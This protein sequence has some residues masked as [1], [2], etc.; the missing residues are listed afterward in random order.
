M[1]SQFA[2]LIFVLGIVL[3]GAALADGPLP[4]EQNIPEWKSL[5]PDLEVTEF[6]S[7]SP[8]LFS[9]QLLFVR[10]GLRDFV[11]SVGMA[12]EFGMGRATA[13]VLAEKAGGA[14]A[15]NA[16][17]FDLDRKPLGL[18]INR[19]LTRNPLHKGGRVLTGIFELN[20]KGPTVR[21]RD[22]YDS[23]SAIEA[24]Q[25]GPRLLAKGQKIEGL[26]DRDVATRRSG[27][28]IDKQGRLLLFCS[29]SNLGGITL[30]ELQSLLLNPHIG[31]VDALNLDGG[32]SAQMYLKVSETNYY[33]PGTDEVPVVLL[34]KAK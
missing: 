12:R 22:G 2:F 19:G 4:S 14:V 13:K 7:S 20:S 10:T 11:L 34:L 25:A 1:R 21:S 30:L 8:G 32:G 27:V 5:A 33:L 17:F 18:V 23:S 16:N 29:A 28:C 26:S 15:V 9:S 24:I 31:C 3:N 6:G